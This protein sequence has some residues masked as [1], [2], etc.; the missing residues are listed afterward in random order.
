MVYF[1]RGC[2]YYK[3]FDINGFEISQKHEELRTLPDI[4]I[5]KR[6]GNPTV[7]EKNK[8]GIRTLCA[9]N[10]AIYFLHDMYSDEEM[11]YMYSHLTK[12]IIKVDWDGTIQCKYVLDQLL[13]EIAVDEKNRRIYA[14]YFDPESFTEKLGYFNY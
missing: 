10:E 9:T 3:I 11:G 13:K 7:S 2:Y 6:S 12:E 8:G 14:T 5:S 1:S 4:V